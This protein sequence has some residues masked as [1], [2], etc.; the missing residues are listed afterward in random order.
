MLYRPGFF[1]ENKNKN[2]DHSL[3]VFA[4]YFLIAACRAS[5]VVYGTLRLGMVR[6]CK[7]EN[8]NKNGLL[9]NNE[10]RHQ[11]LFNFS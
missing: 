4:I 11:M 5:R 6:Y 1:I 10:K 2:N 9:K 7:L 8:S 3:T